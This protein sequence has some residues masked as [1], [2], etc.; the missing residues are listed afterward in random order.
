MNNSNANPIA[1]VELFFSVLTTSSDVERTM[2]NALEGHLSDMQWS[3]EIGTE[4]RLLLRGFNPE[5]P[6]LKVFGVVHPGNI[7]INNDIHE[8]D[9]IQ[10]ELIF[11]IKE[12]LL[13]EKTRRVKLFMGSNDGM[14]NMS[15]IFE[16]T[17]YEL[18]A[19]SRYVHKF[20]IR[21]KDYGRPWELHDIY[22]LFYIGD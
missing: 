9:A 4:Q 5:N 16:Y 14:V 21:H 19:R 2:Q 7:I 1:I 15:E 3:L 13:L 18:L 22:P 10:E 20:M 17:Y 12:M 6:K 11:A 8:L